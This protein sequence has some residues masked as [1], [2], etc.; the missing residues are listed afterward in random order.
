MVLHIFCDDDGV[1]FG[2]VSGED[3]GRCFCGLCSGSGGRVK[4]SVE[5]GGAAAIY[6]GVFS[7]AGGGDGGRCSF[8]VHDVLRLGCREPALVATKFHAP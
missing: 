3:T 6:F 8:I 2:V 5:G 7:I 1:G 4:A